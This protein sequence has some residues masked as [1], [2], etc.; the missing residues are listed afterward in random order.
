M[1]DQQINITP[2]PE[3]DDPRYL[4]KCTLFSRVRNW[5]EPVCK[6]GCPE[7]ELPRK[8]EARHA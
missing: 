5:T 3:P 8:E 6:C 1:S 4:R 2:P 7:F